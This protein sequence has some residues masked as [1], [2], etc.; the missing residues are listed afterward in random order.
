MVNKYL[1]KY[2]DAFKD[3]DVK[4]TRDK[5]KTTME[6]FEENYV[7]KTDDGAIIVF[8][9]GDPSYDFACLVLWVDE[10]I[11]NR[12]MRVVDVDIR[13]DVGDILLI[14]LFWWR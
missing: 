11:M 3:E 7:E 14:K 12:G 2:V 5:L 8:D 10:Y 4:G 1:Q 13:G 6:E 9:L